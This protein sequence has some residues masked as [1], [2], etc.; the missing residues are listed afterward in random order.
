MA[1]TSIHIKPCNVGNSEHHN[2]REKTLDYVAK[3]RTH[4]NERWEEVT[5]LPGYQSSLSSEVKSLTGRT[6]QKKATPIREGVIVIQA[7]TTMNDLRRFAERLEKAYKL[8]TLQI[9]IHRDE[10]HSATTEDVAPGLAANPGEFICNQHAHIV[11]DWMDHATGK[12]IKINRQQMS[13]IQ[14][15]LADTLGMERGIKSDKKHLSAMQYKTAM[16]EQELTAIE[17]PL[18]EI[19]S[20]TEEKLIQP[21]TQT[22]WDALR[23]LFSPK[24]YMG[25]IRSKMAVVEDNFKK[26]IRERQRAERSLKIE[27]IGKS[28]LAG[29]LELK[30]EQIEALANKQ[31]VVMS[32]IIR[33]LSD[34]TTENVTIDVSWNDESKALAVKE[35]EAWRQNKLHQERMRQLRE[36]Q[37]RIRPKR[38]QEPPQGEQRRSR[39]VHM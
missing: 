24:R 22:R 1:K 13:E 26:A 39:G 12:S 25:K 18:A 31:V 29:K 14:T 33:T 17:M 21:L 7:N 3:E 23:L 19:I 4:L 36:Q 5:N 6:M 28:E 20:T 15:L 11:F 9:Y 32:N 8:K 2:R 27:L 34:K 38:G 37:E 30:P 16:A 35:N 10:G